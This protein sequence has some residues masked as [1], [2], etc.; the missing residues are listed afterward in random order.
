MSEFH[1]IPSE[2]AVMR[3]LAKQYPNVDSAMAET[4]RLSAEL[5][6]PK[7]TVHVISDVHGEAKKL[8][9]II[10]N[11]SG[12]LR[13]LAQELFGAR[14]DAKEFQDFL[15]LIF[16]PDE[17][18]AQVEKSL[19]DTKDICR[20]AHRVLSDM[21]EILRVLCR[22][23]PMKYAIAVFPAEYRDLFIEILHQPTMDHGREYIGAVVEDMA[24]RGSVWMMIQHT[25]RAIRKLAVSEIVLD[26]D[27]WDRGPRGDWVVDYLMKQLRVAFVWGNHDTAWFGAALGHEALIAHVLRLSLR[28]RRLSQLEEGYGITLQP[29]ELLVRTVYAD[30]P[31]SCYALKGTGLRDAVTMQ[32]MQKAAAIMQF[33]LEGQMIARNPEW[34]MDHRRLM[35]RIDVSAGT[36][37]IDGKVYPLKDKLWP[38][39]D[40]KNP[41]ELSEAEKTCMARI[42][43]SFL[44]SQ[45]LTMH[46][47]HMISNGSMYVR[48]DDHLIFHGCVPVDEKGEFL[49]MT[50]DGK[51][52]TG[53]ALFEAI[54]KIV[55]R[56]PE[57]KALKDLDLLWYLWSGPRSPL[58]GKDRITTLEASL[59]EDKHTHE[60]TKNPYFNLI[61]EKEFCD[62]ILIEF[63]MNTERGLIVNGHVPVKVEKGENP[64]KRSG[65]AITIDGAF[66]EAYGDHGYTLVL[67]AGQTYL[68]EHSHFESVEAALRDGVD[69][70]P[71]IT[72][73]RKWETPRRVADT[74]RGQL[75]RADIEL[76]EKLVEAYQQNALREI[77]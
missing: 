28:Y 58:F 50:L 62:R 36:I 19:T 76:L 23:Y 67:E 73:I 59:I 2:L 65:K 51:V 18:G 27:C 5:T 68:A 29:L 32:R 11:A 63:G 3:V 61:H 17:M 7:G 42:R 44:R 48:R 20:F 49:S 55:S 53:R 75:I 54:E 74:E 38:T 25:S 13:P 60:E 43:E 14:M 6:Q 31:A 10:N 41:Y 37:E 26:G 24:R 72:A 46:V 12:T 30:D 52:Y 45:K 40:P 1:A 33:K 77:R 64:M 9:H 35:H 70:I 47:N 16:Y 71:K 15:N 21:F 34:A 39:L 8:R 56:T 22:R 4:A 69:I 66:S 57:K